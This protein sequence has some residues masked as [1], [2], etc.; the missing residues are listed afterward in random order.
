[1][2]DRTLATNLGAFVEHPT[3]EPGPYR[4]D[5]EGRPYVPVGDGGIVIGAA[6]GQSVFAHVGD[7]VGPGACLVHP[8]GR[9]RA[10]LTAL[11][12]VGNRVTVTGGPSEGAGGVVVG[13]RGER[14]RVIAWFPPDALLSL[15]PGDPVMVRA[16]GQ[17]LALEGLDQVSVAN[18]DPALLEMLPIALGRHGVRA[19]VRCEVGSRLAGNGM[20]RPAHL[21]DLDLQLDEDDGAGAGLSLGDLVAV[22]DLDSRYHMG[23]RRGWR[24][25]GL[26]VHGSSPQPGHGPGLVPLLTGPGSVLGAEAEGSAHTGLTASILETILARDPFP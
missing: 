8:D 15:R 25:V 18:L 9:A 4:V 10:A 20:G 12:C 13:K 26:V 11:S 1:M 5:R 3:L 2:S 17:G 16:Q 21:W 6:L 24:T 7:H 23:F 19:G 14:G 22:S